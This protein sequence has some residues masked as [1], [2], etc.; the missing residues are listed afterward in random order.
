MSPHAVTV[1]FLTQNNTGRNNCGPSVV[2]MLLW[3]Y[4]NQIWTVSKAVRATKSGS[5][6]PNGFSTG[7]DIKRGI[8]SE[9]V[10][11]TKHVGLLPGELLKYTEAG[12][13]VVCLVDYASYFDNPTNYLFA[14]WL[15]FCGIWY[16]PTGMPYAVLNDPLRYEV[17][18][19]PWREF[20][21]SFTTQSS[22]VKFHPVTGKALRNPDGSYQTG[23]NA[24]GVCIVPN[25][26][27]ADW[28]DINHMQML[29]ERYRRV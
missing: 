15:I 28:R 22:Y 7:D 29:I 25:L 10:E 4:L 5:A 6:Y 17:Y 9:K 21:K 1:P 11:S 14:H 8:Y 2:A 19:A 26:P 20:S 3:L 24:S 13:P 16:G 23:L 27:P 12:I 18:R